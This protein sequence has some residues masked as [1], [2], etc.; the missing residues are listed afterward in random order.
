MAQGR[1]FQKWYERKRRHRQEIDQRSP[2]VVQE[3]FSTEYIKGNVAGEATF[4][5]FVKGDPLL[6]LTLSRYIKGDTAFQFKLQVFVKS[7]TVFASTTVFIKSDTAL[8]GQLTEL[9]KGEVVFTFTAVF[10]KGDANLVVNAPL[11]DLGET[12]P[13]TKPG[14]ISRIFLQVQSVKTDVT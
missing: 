13:S 12:P 7:D 4:T 10:V 1:R 14:A 2:A 6:S 9:I 5:Q 8:I 11:G 3:P